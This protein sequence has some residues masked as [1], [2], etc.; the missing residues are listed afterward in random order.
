MY[1]KIEIK[2]KFLKLYVFL[3]CVFFEAESKFEICFFFSVASSVFE[4]WF[5]KLG[6]SA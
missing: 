2:F 5:S 4:L 1:N 6:W 3:I